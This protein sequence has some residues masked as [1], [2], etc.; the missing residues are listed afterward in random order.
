MG[1]IHCPNCQT[2]EGETYE[3]DHTEDLLCFECDEP[4]DLIPEHDEGDD[5]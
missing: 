2:I 5:R 1:L 4:V 3:D